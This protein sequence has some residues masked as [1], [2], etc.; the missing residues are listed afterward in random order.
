MDDKSFEPTVE[1]RRRLDA[2]LD[3]I[4]QRLDGQGMD[5]GERRSVVDDIEA[6]ATEMLSARS[7]SP[8]LDAVEAVLAALDAPDAYG[9]GAESGHPAAERTVVSAHAAPALF[10]TPDADVGVPRF[11]K[12][13]GAVLLGLGLLGSIVVASF[14]FLA[15]APS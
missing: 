15:T 12:I 4:E 5:R 3:E 13:A 6:Q 10:W 14:L 7:S 11:V 9:P 1:A 8:G 2:Y